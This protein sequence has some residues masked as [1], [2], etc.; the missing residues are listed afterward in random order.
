M[1]GLYA[2]FSGKE[3]LLEMIMNI[4][5][6]TTWHIIEEHLEDIDS[7]LSKLRAAIRTH[8]FLSEAMLPWFYFSYMEARHLGPTQKERAK[9]S[10]LKTEKLF[11]DILEEGRGK[12]VFGAEDSTLAASVIKAMVQDWYVKRWKYAKRNV[13]VD[14]Y[15]RL[16]VEFVESFCLSSEYRQNNKENIERHHASSKGQ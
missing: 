16:I 14:R 6:N 1:G 9:A 8:I 11:S 5:N 13:S 3:D 12:G 15:A 2:Y 7:P 10:E 4:G